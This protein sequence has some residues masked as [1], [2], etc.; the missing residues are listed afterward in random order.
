MKLRLRRKTATTAEE[1]GGG[2]RR[3]RHDVDGEEA[4]QKEKKRWGP[5]SVLLSPVGL[6]ISCLGRPF[7][8]ASSWAGRCLFVSC[9]PVVQ[10]A[11]WDDCGRRHHHHDRHFYFD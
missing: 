10:C 6:V 11:G 2:G 1:A 4:K 7:V 3:R 5:A 9:Y 8:T